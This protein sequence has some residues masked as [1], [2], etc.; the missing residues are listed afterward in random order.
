MI[1]MRRHGKRHQLPFLMYVIACTA[2]SIGA[3]AQPLP[4]PLTNQRGTISG[5]VKAAGTASPIQG[6]LIDITSSQTRNSITTDVQGRYVFR[7][8]PA[9][10]YLVRASYRAPIGQNKIITLPSEMATRSLDFD[11]QI[12]G[13]ISG[14]VLDEMGEPLPDFL[15]LLMSREYRLGVVSYSFHGIATTNHRGEYRIGS[16]S[17]GRVYL[18]QTKSQDQHVAAISNIPADPKLRR[19]TYAPTYYPR[20]AT[21]ET[22][23][24]VA[25]RSGEQLEGIDIRVSRSP[26]YCVEGT[27]RID[28]GAGTLAF[29]IAPTEPS[30]GVASFMYQLNGTSSPDGNIRVCDLSR[31]EYRITVYQ[32]SE[33]P[34]RPAFYGTASVA[35]TNDDAKITINPLPRL[36]L[37]GKVVLDG[38]APN[39]PLE[40][41]LGVGLQPLNGTYIKDLDLAMEVRVSIPGDFLFPGLRME[42]YEVLVTGLRGGLYIRDILYGGTSILHKP[43]RLGS[44]V[45]TGELRIALGSDGAALNVLLKDSDGNPVPNAH[46]LIIP[47]GGHSELELSAVLTWGQ[48]DEAGAYSA[49]G[50]APGTYSIL[51]TADGLDRTPESIGRVWRA[52]SKAKEIE[53]G[54]SANVQVTLKPIV[55]D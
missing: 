52:R 24:G 36:P 22:A 3:I 20:S 46:V 34:L 16:L 5:V 30:H 19:Q 47:D 21:I 13:A 49:E 31:G 41:Q 14:K 53:L 9:G 29:R 50:V 39:G 28:G 48:T 51:A 45:G 18:L 1:T 40:F 26:S 11:L 42:D 15:V 27:L 2:A 25:V 6:A 7:N 32:T 10:R 55:L 38:K 4:K 37:P 8:L 23:T 33:D 44:A 43:L 17:P 35:I 54:P 12:P